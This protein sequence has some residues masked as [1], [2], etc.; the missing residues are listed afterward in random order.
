MCVRKS[1]KK[2][3]HDREHLSD[4]GAT[5]M[6]NFYSPVNYDFYARQPY[7]P[8][9][10]KKSIRLLKVTKDAATGHR[11]Y[12]LT[13]EISLAEARDTY[14]AISYCAGDPKNTQQL[15][16]NG[17]LFNAFAN[18]AQAIEET[19]HYREC[20]YGDT[21][22]VLWADQ[23]CINQSDVSERSHQV[24][25][26][27]DV[28]ENARDT[29]ICLLTPS[30]G[31]RKITAFGWIRAMNKKTAIDCNEWHI[32]V[33]KGSLE[34]LFAKLDVVSP[35]LLVFEGMAAISRSH[36]VGPAC[37]QGYWDFTKILDSPWWTRAWIVQEFVASR[38]A[39]FINGTESIPCWLLIRFL[40]LFQ[41]ISN[42]FAWHRFP[43]YNAAWEVYGQRIRPALA[44]AERK[45]LSKPQCLSDLLLSLN[46]QS[47]SDK[48]DLV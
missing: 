38:G 17:L 3:I 9:E 5:N 19:C 24:G 1:P 22:T 12:S 27:Y 34:H 21:D 15:I 32:L 41:I 47:A 44:V 13:N 11:T 26:M 16:V 4:Y 20:E 10:S 28:Y 31:H 42:E 25:M 33:Q 7:Q 48:R 36:G 8:F 23:I 29:A 37:E 45:W 14:T 40:Q 43:H 35:D 2:H 46:Q 6:D 18:L 30:S 39:Y